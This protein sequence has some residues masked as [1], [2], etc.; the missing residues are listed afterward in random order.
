MILK[1][2]SKWA[3]SFLGLSAMTIMK[4]VISE[5]RDITDLGTVLSS[6]DGIDVLRSTRDLDQAVIAS[7]GLRDRLVRRLTNALNALKAATE[8]FPNYRE[9]PE[10]TE[11]LGLCYEALEGLKNLNAK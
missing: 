10:V 2:A 5:S 7:G 6:S 11:L 1:K 8:D 4:K 3:K 9:D